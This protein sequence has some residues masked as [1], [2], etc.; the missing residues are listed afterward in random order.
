MLKKCLAALVM[1]GLIGS[2]AWAAVEF[3][4]DKEQVGKLHL[5]LSEKGIKQIIPG[6]PARGPEDLWGADGQ[7]HQE[8][9]YPAAGIT[10]GMVSE[11]KGGPKSVERITITSPSTLRTQRG[12][13]IGSSEA[14]VVKAYGRFRNA[15]DSKPGELLVAGSIFGGVLFQLQQG[16]VSGIFIG[17]SAE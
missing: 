5:G 2:A 11:K 10:L 17:A 13:G 12:I 4:Y 1:V 8:W 9:K 3:A 14:E 6:Q 15:E 16:K 7:Y